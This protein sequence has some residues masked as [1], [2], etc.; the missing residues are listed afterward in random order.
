MRIGSRPNRLVVFWIGSWASCCHRCYGRRLPGVCL[1][2][3]SSRWRS[4]C[5]WSASVRFARLCRKNI[6]KSLPTLTAPREVCVLRWSNRRVKRFVRSMRGK[7][8]R[9]SL[10]YRPMPI[11]SVTAVTKRLSLDRIHLSLHRH[12]SRLR[13]RVLAFRSKR[14]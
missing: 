14:Q 13:A 4:V 2:D 7:P 3:G 1:P 11:K 10:C 6:G 8:R 5:W 12:C 9:R